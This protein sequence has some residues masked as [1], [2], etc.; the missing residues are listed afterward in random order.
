MTRNRKSA[1]AAGAKFE[2]DIADYLKDTLQD[3]RIDRR[4]KTGAKDRGDITGLRIHGQRLVIECKN[5]ATLKIG[6]WIREA[7]V[8]RGNDDALAGMVAHKRHG[9]GSPADQLI[10]MTLRDL[11]A[12]ISGTRPEEDK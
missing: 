4:V 5:E 12:L 11:T 6:P 10:T 8:E 7:E 2:R 9:V 3:D 1:K